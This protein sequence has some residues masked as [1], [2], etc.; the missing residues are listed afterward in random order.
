MV[1]QFGKGATS[2]KANDDARQCQ[3]GDNKWWG[4]WQ[5]ISSPPENWAPPD[6]LTVL[7]AGGGQRYIAIYA[8]NAKRTPS[9]KTEMQ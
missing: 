9:R 2:E 8:E 6:W 3:P 4:G 5:F 7:K 1:E